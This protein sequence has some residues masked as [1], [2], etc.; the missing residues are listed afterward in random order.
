[1]KKNKSMTL[2]KIATAKKMVIVTGEPN[3]EYR[4]VKAIPNPDNNN[5]DSNK[6]CVTILPTSNIHAKTNSTE[7]NIHTEKT[8]HIGNITASTEV[9]IDYSKICGISIGIVYDF[10]KREDLEYYL[11]ILLKFNQLAP[12]VDIVIFGYKTEN[13][14]FIEQS[15]LKFLYIKPVSIIHW[16]KTL[17]AAQIDFLFIP[18]IN[19][20]YNN[21]S[22]TYIKYVESGLHNIP[23]LAPMVH[24]YNEIVK[25][26]QNGFLY[27][28]QND[29]LDKMI[30][31]ITNPD[32]MKKV[33]QNA[34]NDVMKNFHF[35]NENLAYLQEIFT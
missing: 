3:S 29:L 18:L 24:P 21:T 17:R 15:G 32:E 16:F 13:D 31:I 30:Y 5:I 28:N 26:K 27:N 23:V 20:A 25:D 12:L 8:T 19:N 9:K 7:S 11:P 33:G 1:M 4:D 14:E 2:G 34:Y 10:T 22:E 6:P 35:S